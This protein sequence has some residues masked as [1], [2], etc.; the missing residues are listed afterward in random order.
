LIWPFKSNARHKEDPVKL[1][2]TLIN[3]LVRRV[4][5]D[6]ACAAKDFLIDV[7]PAPGYED[8]MRL[9]QMAALLMAITDEERKTPTYRVVRKTIEDSFFSASSDP[10]EKLFGQV[11]FAM[12]DL[13]EL[14]AQKKEMSWARSWL[15]EAGIHE[16]NPA[17]LALFAS[18]W[19]GFYATVVKSLRQLE[20]A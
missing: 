5:V 3:E 10:N 2:Q 7:R 13:A 20:P 6:A 12:R 1:A 17:K 16:S 18:H 15:A 4:A 8:K 14:I 11:K 9:Y 19:L